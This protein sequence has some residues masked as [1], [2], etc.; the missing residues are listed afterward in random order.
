MVITVFIEYGSS[1]DGN[2]DINLVDE[3]YQDNYWT[4]SSRV[5]GPTR[6]GPFSYNKGHRKATLW[7]GA[8]TVVAEILDLDYPPYHGIKSM[9]KGRVFHRLK[10]TLLR[11][12]SHFWFQNADSEEG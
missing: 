12:G 9:V 2:V 7:D 5:L 3:W 8:G 10:N 11:Y 1:V 4:T 6:S